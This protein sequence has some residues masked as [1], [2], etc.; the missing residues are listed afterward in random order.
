LTDLD[1]IYDYIGR[2]RRSPQAADR[3]IDRIHQSCQVYASQPGM[4]EARPDLGE[5]V[6][7]FVVGSHVVIY[8]PLDDGIRVLRVFEGHRNYPALFRDHST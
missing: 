8:R 3:T 7:I 2:T 1:G 6:R 5:N 4:G